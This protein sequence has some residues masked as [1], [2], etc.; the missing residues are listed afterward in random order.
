MNR[1]ILASH[2]RLDLTLRYVILCP[3]PAGELRSVVVKSK[4][5]GPPPR[6][7]PLVFSLTPSCKPR[8]VACG[9]DVTSVTFRSRSPADPRSLAA[10][11]NYPAG[12]YIRALF[13]VPPLRCLH[14]QQQ[15]CWLIGFWIVSLQP[16]PST[17]PRANTGDNSLN[18]AA[19]RRTNVNISHLCLLRDEAQSC[20]RF[21]TL[22]V[23]FIL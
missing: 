7:I 15:L 6:Q 17:C 8:D 14:C 21:T 1:Q 13:W 20:L 11:V 18:P 22:K 16:P 19:S 10:K 23:M 5:P 2:W 12:L 3:A 9:R 4:S